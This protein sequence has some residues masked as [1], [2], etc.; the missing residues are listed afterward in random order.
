MLKFGD[1]VK[2]TNGFFAGGDGVVI[3]ER[4]SWVGITLQ[5]VYYT[6]KGTK[7]SIDFTAE[8]DEDNLTKIGE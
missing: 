4:I 3:N 6:I 5:Y 7:N 8:I 2:I 1:K